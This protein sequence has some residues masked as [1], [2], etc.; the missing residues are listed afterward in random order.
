MMINIRRLPRTYR[1]VR[2]MNIGKRIL[3]TLVILGLGIAMVIII[4]LHVAIGFLMVCAYLILFGL[5][6]ITIVWAVWTITDW[7][8]P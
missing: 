1:N 6:F 7:L 4:P 2:R 5:A 8:I 3:A